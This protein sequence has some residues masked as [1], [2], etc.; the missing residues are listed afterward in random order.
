MNF[1][2]N[3]RARRLR[4]QKAIK[5]NETFDNSFFL[6]SNFLFIFLKER[7]WWEFEQIVWQMFSTILNRVYKKQVNFSIRKGGKQ[8]WRKVLNKFEE[9]SEQPELKSCLWLVAFKSDNQ[10]CRMCYILVE[11]YE[12]RSK[13]MNSIQ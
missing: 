5:L 12:S 10:T 3:T 6:S 7:L 11:N 1:G 4:K 2:K 8:V 13:P 9:I